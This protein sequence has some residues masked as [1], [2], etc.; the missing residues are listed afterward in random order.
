MEK[1]RRKEEASRPPQPARVRGCKQ[2][3][4]ENA[5]DRSCFPMSVG[6]APSTMLAALARGA[7]EPRIYL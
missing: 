1:A 3:K 6:K 4:E 7:A 2:A 5:R